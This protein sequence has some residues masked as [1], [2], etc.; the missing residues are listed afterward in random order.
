[1]CDNFLEKVR[2]H[3][4]SKIFQSDTWTD[5]VAEIEFE[6]YRNG[7]S[8]REIREELKDIRKEVREH[9]KTFE[10]FPNNEVLADLNPK[11]E[12]LKQQFQ[13]VLNKHI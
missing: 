12:K 11:L 9:L 4:E 2:K 1:M 7:I 10:P 5:I 3:Q 8:Q 13:R 6:G